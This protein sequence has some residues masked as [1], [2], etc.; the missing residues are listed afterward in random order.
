MLV[1]ATQFET[2]LLNLVVNAFD[3]TPV[4]GRIE[5]KCGHA[6][7]WDGQVGKLPS[8]NY[9]AVTVSDNGEGMDEATQRRAIEP[10][11]TT[12]AQGKGSGLGL[13]QVFG[14]VQQC[15]GDMRITSAKV[16][17]TTI[18]MYFPVLDGGVKH[19]EAPAAE[20]VLI[21]D[22]Q[23]EVLDITAELFRTLGFEVLAAESGERAMEVLQRG[24]KIDLLFSD[25]VMTGMTGVELA[26][27]ALKDTPDLRV[28]L[29][30]GLAGIE[31]EVPAEGKLQGFPFI[32]KPYKLND[33]IRKLRALA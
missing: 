18:T 20:T 13:S 25:V 3:A 17:G 8:G 21:V 19:N 22:D 9:I 7:L 2:A 31:G 14:M 12:K 32:A 26:R 10:F 5:V 6:D 1:D 16:V 11:F 23:P 15:G 4:G 33:V 27:Q 28:I 30:S 24:P 29:V